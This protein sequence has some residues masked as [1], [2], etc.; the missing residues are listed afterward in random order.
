MN[1]NREKQLP[2][3]LDGD[4]LSLVAENPDLI[5]GRGRSK[6]GTFSMEVL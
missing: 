2:L 1:H 5:R 6:E 3:I 4:G